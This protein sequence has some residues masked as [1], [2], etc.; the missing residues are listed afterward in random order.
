MNNNNASLERA[1]RLLVISGCWTAAAM[2]CFGRIYLQYHSWAQVIV[3]A[4]VGSVFGFL[5]FFFTHFILA[6][7]FPYVV[8][9]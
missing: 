6:P 1:A 4:I 9:W 8:S 7:K 3:G 2:V 5:W